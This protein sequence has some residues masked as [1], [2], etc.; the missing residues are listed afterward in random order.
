MKMSSN[1]QGQKRQPNLQHPDT[2]QVLF[3]HSNVFATPNFIGFPVLSSMQKLNKFINFKF[4]QSRFCYN[5]NY[6]NSTVYSY[7]QW[8]SEHDY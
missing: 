1:F 8:N 5:N 7:T 4:S 2:G 6:H 3:F